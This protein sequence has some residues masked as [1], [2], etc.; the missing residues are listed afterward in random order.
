MIGLAKLLTQL[1]LSKT[2]S[3]L[4]TTFLYVHNKLYYIS[5]SLDIMISQT[6]QMLSWQ[7]DDIMTAKWVLSSSNQGL[8]CKKKKSFY[9]TLKDQIWESLCCQ[10]S[11]HYLFYFAFLSNEISFILHAI[12]KELSQLLVKN[13]KKWYTF[14]SICVFHLA[15]IKFRNSERLRFER[16]LQNVT[17]PKI[18]PVIKGREKIMSPGPYSHITF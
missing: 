17:I 8:T 5:Y 11:H 14:I 2:V 12:E 7:Q 3:H 9:F 1:F 4:D 13:N 6:S 16:R 18:G 15:I 10:M